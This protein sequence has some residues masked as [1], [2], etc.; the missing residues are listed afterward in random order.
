MEYIA[1]VRLEICFRSVTHGPTGP[2]NSIHTMLSRRCFQYCSFLKILSVGRCYYLIPLSGSICSEEVYRFLPQL[3]WEPCG[4][5]HCRR[6]IVD[7]NYQKKTPWTLIARATAMTDGPLRWKPNL[8][9]D[10]EKTKKKKIKKRK[11]IQKVLN[12]RKSQSVRSSYCHW[13]PWYMSLVARSN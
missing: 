3:S 11:R 6:A 13:I 2:S 5:V 7:V 10:R 9:E 1:V 4:C 8:E 12:S